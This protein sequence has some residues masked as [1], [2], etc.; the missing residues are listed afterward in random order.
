VIQNG[1]ANLC[2]EH[3]ERA[4]ENR[5]ENSLAESG[6]RM[7][8]TDWDESVLGTLI[9]SEYTPSLY[10]ELKQNLEPAYS[11]NEKSFSTAS[12]MQT[13]SSSIRATFT[14]LF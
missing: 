12:T 4:I 8:V 2:Q 1:D 11:V 14:S 7:T 10:K 3:Q 13:E 9:D 5:A 6:K